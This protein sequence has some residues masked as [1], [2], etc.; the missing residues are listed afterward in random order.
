MSISAEFQR[1]IQ[2]IETNQQVYV[3]LGFT[4]LNELETSTAHF[5]E[6]AIA[7]SELSPRFAEAAQKLYFLAPP[8]VNGEVTN[9]RKAIINESQRQIEQL[10]EKINTASNLT[11]E[12]ALGIVKFFGELYNVG[13]LFKGILKKHLEIF[14]A[15]KDDCFFANRCFYLL[16][17]TVKEKV[18]KVYETP[19]YTIVIVSLIKMI[20]E[21]E[22]NP[23]INE[24]PKVAIPRAPVKATAPKTFEEQFPTLNKNTA[25]GVLSDSIKNI[26][27]DKVASF[28]RLL[29]DLTTSNTQEILKKF[30]E[31]QKHRFEDGTW[32]LY[33]DI[34][35]NKAL[36]EHELAEAVVDICQKL[37]R[38]AEAWQGVKTEEYKKYI[39][40]LINAKLE[41]IFEESNVAARKKQIVS[42]LVLIQKLLEHSQTSI[43]DIAA[44]IKVLTGCA[45]SDNVLAS[46]IILQL[47]VIIKQKISTAKIRKLPVEQRMEIIQVV[48]S[49][50]SG[51]LTEKIKNKI[52]EIAE[53]IDVE[54]IVD[55][56]PFPKAANG[57]LTHDVIAMDIKANGNGFAR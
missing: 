56:F 31:S 5:F 57:H 53:Y 49:G 29:E 23:A 41:T 37:P 12:K 9:F 26:W 2:N 39:H 18:R 16:I 8:A 47:L 32:Q 52:K 3:K 55:D 50:Q 17:D 28:Q 6:R 7:R 11:L 51:K 14:H 46:Q 54:Y 42:I 4:S 38:C 1:F 33:Y 25:K 30:G 24:K 21:A 43:G 15:S 10:G 13:F 34:L 22:R 48:S 40:Q 20:D 35:I 19:D 27:E 36:S 44:F 45:K